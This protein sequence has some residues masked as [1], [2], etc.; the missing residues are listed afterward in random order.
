[1]KGIIFITLCLFYLNLCAPENTNN[2]QQALLVQTNLTKEELTQ[3]LNTEAGNEN[4]SVEEVAPDSESETE[5]E[6]EKI[7]KNL[8]NGKLKIKVKLELDLRDKKKQKEHTETEKESEGESEDTP[9]VQTAFIQTSVPQIPKKVSFFNYILAL[10]IMVILM[11]L[12]VL[13]T[14][15]KKNRKYILNKVKKN[16]DYLL[17]DN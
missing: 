17:E 3:L 9:V 13:S 14:T 12:F 5:S 4:T 6:T 15:S 2:V 10:L 16:D 7:F 1:M 8:R 11:S